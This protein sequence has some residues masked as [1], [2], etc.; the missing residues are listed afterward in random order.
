VD[1]DDL[2]RFAE[3]LVGPVCAPGGDGCD[4]PAWTQ[5]PADLPV[6]HCLMMDVDYD[7]DADLHDFAVLQ[8]PLGAP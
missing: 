8:A 6:Q 3:C 5:P 1:L 4:V 7:W 2:P